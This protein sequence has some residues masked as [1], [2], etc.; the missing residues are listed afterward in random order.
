MKRQS[1]VLSPFFG[2]ISFY[3][4][5]CCH[6]CCWFESFNRHSLCKNQKPASNNNNCYFLK[7][8]TE[9]WQMIYVYHHV[10]IMKKSTFHLIYSPYQ[11]GSANFLRCVYVQSPLHVCN[12]RMVFSRRNILLAEAIVAPIQQSDVRNHTIWMKIPMTSHFWPVE[13]L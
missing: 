7:T 11:H 3:H 9:K 13:S 8:S 4:S 12:G 5:L 6:R 2:F 1:I 10:T